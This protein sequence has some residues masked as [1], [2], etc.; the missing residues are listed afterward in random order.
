MRHGQAVGP[1][2]GPDGHRYLTVAGREKIRAVA[3]RLGELGH[4]PTHVY[5]SPLVRAVQTAEILVQAVGHSGPSVVHAPLVPGGTTAHALSV[6]D[7]HAGD[8]VVA[9]VTHEPIVR[10]LAGH[11][12]GVGGAFPGFRTS[13]VAVL[14]VDPTGARL[15]GRLDPDALRWRAPEDLTP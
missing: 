6:L 12:S 10:A 3:A 13:G 2:D 11:L 4:A 9:L 1:G 14:E 15:L 8:E 5:T 7:A